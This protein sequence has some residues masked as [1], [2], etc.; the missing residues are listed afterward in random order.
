MSKVGEGVHNV[1]K[2]RA[3]AGG[4]VLWHVTIK[5]Q[6]ELAPG[7]PLHM[8]LKVFPDKKDLDLEELKAKVK[9][10]GIKTPNPEKLKFKTT[11][12][13]SERD[14]KKYYMLLIEGTDK[15]YSDFY[16]SLK[17]CGTVYKKFMPHITIDKG[18]YDKINKEGIKPHEISFGPLS[19]EAGSGNTV[20]EFAKSE[21]LNIIR[22]TVVLN[23]DLQKHSR[24][25][26]LS[27]E[28]LTNY[29][30]DNPGLEKQ[31]MEKH[32]KRLEHHFGDNK[33]LIQIAWEQ[34]L[35]KAY[36]LKEKK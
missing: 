17:H 26:R 30:Q 21:M 8:S 9:E 6:D 15:S 33:E 11:I 25:I 3:A 19:I 27:N 29:L 35:E 22:E 18:L 14:G 10:F 28:F 16:D 7:I 13:T 12:F 34:G 20:H 2:E 4:D 31:V 23:M 5:G 1:Y 24:A 32:Q 36:K